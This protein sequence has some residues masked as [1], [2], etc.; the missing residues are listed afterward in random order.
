MTRAATP[1]TAAS[2]IRSS[3]GARASSAI[4]LLSKS[5]ASRPRA[6]RAE[7]L[8]CGPRRAPRRPAPPIV[9]RDHQVDLDSVLA[10]VDAGLC[11]VG[12]EAA[13]CHGGVDSRIGK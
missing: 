9:F 4:V 13:F 1:A 7:R 8:P 10:P 12:N 2:M 3:P 5:A 6:L 11:E